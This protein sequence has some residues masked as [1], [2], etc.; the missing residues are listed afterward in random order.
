MLVPSFPAGDVRR[1]YLHWT[2]GD[3]RTVY[4][5][6]HFC[7]ALDAGGS[8]IV[9]T[10]NDVC[11]NMRDVRTGDAP[12]APHTAGRNS[13]ALGLALCG[14]SEATPTDFGRFPL[15][16]DMLATFCELAAHACAAYAIAV[17]ADAVM[18]HAEAA[19]VDG[20][21]GS[22]D[23]E[24]WDIARLRSEARPLEPG[25]AARAGDLLRARIRSYVVRAT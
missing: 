5:A 23:E 14:M 21:F 19:L 24:R 22:G 7:V 6:Y 15:R 1:V 10:T 9:V 8:P 13:Y 12:Y 18:T 20:Y 2:G 25:D 16:D 3:Y 17:E 11:A 4:A